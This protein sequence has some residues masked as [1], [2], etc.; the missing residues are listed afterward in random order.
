VILEYPL[1][2]NQYSGT[3]GVAIALATIGILA[4][5]LG[6]QDEVARREY[7]SRQKWSQ[8]MFQST[9]EKLKL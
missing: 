7:L 9:I 6:S 3:A 4:R 5:K 8:E 2:M 1:G